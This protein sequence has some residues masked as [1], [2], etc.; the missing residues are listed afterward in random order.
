M[1]H[2]QKNVRGAE[3]MKEVS[4]EKID[5]WEGLLSKTIKNN[6][7]RNVEVSGAN[8][9]S[10]PICNTPE[11]MID[12]FLSGHRP[13]I[14]RSLEFMDTYV[15]KPGLLLDVG[16][17]VSAFGLYFYQKCKM[18]SESIS[19]DC[20]NWELS[21]ITKN[22]RKNL[23]NYSLE[24]NKYDVVCQAEML[25]HYPGDIHRVIKMMFDACKNNGIVFCSVPIGGV[26]IG[27]PKH[28]AM[29]CIPLDANGSYEA[30]LREFYK[31]EIVKI[32][33]KISPNAELLENDIVRTPAFGEIQLTV[34]RKK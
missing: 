4:K 27:L 17:W 7:P 29:K 30:H 25:G 18:K 32:I 16:S 24:K 31:E 1:G 9:L 14:I 28:E 21:G 12:Y 10:D 13:K 22:T 2:A 6:I 19:I 23:C 26:G 5:K 3:S 33:K 11:K 34:W 20:D 15:K 8:G